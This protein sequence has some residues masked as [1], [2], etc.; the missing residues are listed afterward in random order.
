MRPSPLRHP[1]AILRQITNL[2]QKQLADL[3]ECSSSAI[4]GIELKKLPMSRKLALRIAYQTGVNPDWLLANDVSQQPTC[5]NGNPFTKESFEEEQASL[6][7][8]VI[9]VGGLEAI[10]LELITALE[11]LASSAISAHKDNRLKARGKSE[12]QMRRALFSA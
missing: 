4:Q 8:P 11:R 6:K 3:A 7:R 10:R 2:T 1:L 5:G 12:F 9:G